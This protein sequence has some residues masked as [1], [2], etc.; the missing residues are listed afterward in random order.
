MEVTEEFLEFL[1]DAVESRHDEQSQIRLD[2]SGHGM[3]G[4]TCL[5]LV[6][7]EP[8]LWVADMVEAAI[9]EESPDLLDELLIFVRGLKQDSMGHSLIVYNPSAHVSDELIEKFRDRLEDDE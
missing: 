6:V 7:D 1:A 5:G 8:Y 4:R 2:Y 9:G 3:Y